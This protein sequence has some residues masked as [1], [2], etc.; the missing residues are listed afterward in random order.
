MPDEMEQRRMRSSGE[1]PGGVS[2]VRVNCSVPRPEAEWLAKHVE[3]S[4][5]GLLTQAIRREIIKEKEF[6][7]RRRSTGGFDL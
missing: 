4:A 3:L 1:R 5:S 6:L 7:E 2:T